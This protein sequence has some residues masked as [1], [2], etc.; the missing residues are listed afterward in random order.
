MDRISPVGKIQEIIWQS[1]DLGII[2]LDATLFENPIQ[3]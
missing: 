1:R 3:G 2:R